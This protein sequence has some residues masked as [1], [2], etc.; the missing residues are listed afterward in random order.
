MGFASLRIDNGDGSIWNDGSIA[1]EHTTEDRASSE[2]REERGSTSKHR[3]KK[4]QLPPTLKLQK[5]DEPSAVF[6]HFSITCSE[7]LTMRPPNIS[8]FDTETAILARARTAFTVR[9]SP[10]SLNISDLVARC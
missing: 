10:L 2:L 8:F 5:G 9:N 7:L 6:F 1:I 4:H 3:Q